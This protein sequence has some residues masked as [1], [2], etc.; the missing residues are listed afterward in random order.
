V[1]LDANFK[2]G[3]GNFAETVEVYR[4]AEKKKHKIEIRKAEDSSGDA[5]SLLGLLIS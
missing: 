1:K 2:G 5:F 4:S 3:W